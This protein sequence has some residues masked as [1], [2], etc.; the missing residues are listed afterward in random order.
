MERRWQVLQRVQT[1]E[2]A[3]VA[4]LSASLGVTP[5]SIRRDLRY[6]EGLGL[7][8]RTHG[9]AQPVAG[10]RPVSAY[11]ARRL[12]HPASKRAIGHHAASMVSP[13][14]TILI[15]S[16]TTALELVRALPRPLLDAGGLTVV[17]RSLTIAHAL[18]QLP[19]VRLILLGGVYL[20]EFDTFY[21]P[22]V[23]RA[24]QDLH[25]TT[26]FLGADGVSAARGLT[27]DNV[28]ESGLYPLLARCA[29]R[30]VVLADSSKLGVDQLQTILP[31]EQ[32]HTL[33][34]DSAAPAPVVAALQAR[35]MDV[36]VAA[37]GAAL[38]PQGS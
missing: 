12:Q 14:E 24:L 1:G 4:D 16:G 18:H 13:G 10:P 31:I 15:D 7:L 37:G 36:V 34:T 9:G 30:V 32:V 3:S 22:Q 2:P 6:L 19:R 20:H 5:V 25:V 27:T 23:E 35:G 17:T 29:E 28:L 8:R 38:S 21:G 33:L 11:A 26:L